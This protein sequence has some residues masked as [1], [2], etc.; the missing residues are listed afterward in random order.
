MR[1]P[2]NSQN[3]FGIFRETWQVYFL[4]APKRKT[5]MKSKLI[6][7]VICASMTGIICNGAMAA[8]VLFEE[9]FNAGQL[10]NWRNK[11]S[12]SIPAVE[13]IN[14][15]ACVKFEL[16]AGQSAKGAMITMTLDVSKFRG[17]KIKLEAMMKGKDITKAEKDYLGP[18]LMLYFKSSAGQA[19]EDQTKKSGTFDWEKFTATANIPANAEVL[20]LVLG[21][22]ECQGTLWVDDITITIAE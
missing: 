11:E 10:D 4:T 5:K 9:N 16:P 22:Q 13:G 7:T 12:A 1:L 2:G 17:K 14:G 21:M 3:L 8:D 6:M 18:K 19:W 20:E 15:S